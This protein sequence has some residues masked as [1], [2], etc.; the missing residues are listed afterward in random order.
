MAPILQFKR[1]SAGVAGTVPALRPGEPALSLNNFDFFIGFDTSVGGNKFFGS[2]RYWKREDGSN[3][4]ELKLVDEDGTNSINLKSPEGLSGITTYTLPETPTDGYY[5]KTNASGVLEWASVSDGATFDDAT[6][7]GITTFTG[8]IDAQAGLG[9]TGGSTFDDINVTGVGTINH[10]EYNSSTTTGISTVGELYVGITSVLYD[11]GGL[12]TLAGIQTVDA[13]TIATLESLLSLDPNDFSTLNVAGIATIGGL[14]DAEDGLNVDG[15]S[16]LDD[17]NVTGI[18]TFSN[19]IDADILGNAGTATSLSDARDFSV[20]GDVATATS[21]SFDGTGN[22][23]LAVTLSN[24]FS[25]NT[26]GIITATGG[27]V[28]N[29]T[30]TASTATRATQVDTTFEDSNASYY[31]PFVSNSS[32]TTGE[33]IRVGTGIS[34]NPSTNTLDVPN[35]ETAAIKHSN[36]TDSITIDALGNVGIAQT[37]TIE[38]NLTVKGSTTTVNTETLLVKDPVIEVGMEDSAGNLI[39]PTTNTTTDVGTVLHYYTDGAAKKAAFFWDLGTGRVSVASSVTESAGAITVN[40]WGTLEAG[41][42]LMNGKLTVNDCAGSSDVI[43]CTGT[44]RFLDN[45][46][47]DAGSF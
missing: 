30:G 24:T 43:T 11:D 9:V 46:T 28:G 37:L 17:L 20:S 18:A 25:A 35:I 42:F 39:A 13:T 36:G 3:S 1:G 38:G 8:A 4:L 27:F 14:L 12:I 33:T 31:I 45:I 10:L 23:D 15:H 41:S 6:F 29:L 26:S 22:V 19:A 34:F 44:E 32:S 2:H 16:E 7:T 47:V 21:V 5:L 40:T